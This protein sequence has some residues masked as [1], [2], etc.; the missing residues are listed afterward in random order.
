MFDG[1]IVHQ[2]QKLSQ[3]L[4]KQLDKE[5]PRI[6]LVAAGICFAAAARACGLYRKHATDMI[7]TLYN[8]LMNPTVSDAQ[9]AASRLI[10]PY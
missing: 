3:S 10:L 7:E 8:A 6:A 4:L 5:D 1:S 2:G 9:E